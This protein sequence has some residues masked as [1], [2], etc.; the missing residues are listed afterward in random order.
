MR[1]TINNM[2]FVW[3]ASY[4][5]SGNTFLRTILWHC[6]DLPSASVYP[7]DL[8]G[9]KDLEEYVG[10]IEQGPNGEIPFL[11]NCIPLIKTHKHPTNDYPAI[12][13]VRDGRAA[14]VS[15]WKFYDWDLSLDA[16]IEGRHKYGTWSSHVH[17]WSPDTRPHTLLLKYED[18]VSDLPATLNRISFFLERDILKKKIPKRETIAGADGRWV[19]K[20]SD[21][22]TEI[23]DELMERFTEINGEMLKRMGYQ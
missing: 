10:H 22:R 21:W 5:R 13:V 12:Y 15:L 4:P 17:S 16:V 19:K 14:S 20:K 23:S 2:K 11:E 7:N 1:D 18:M 3:L 8:K 6:F 9:N